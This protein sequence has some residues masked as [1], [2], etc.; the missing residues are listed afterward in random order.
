MKRTVLTDGTNRWF[1]ED[2]SEYFKEGKR[3]DGSNNISLST[4]S[5]WEH[6]AL[7]RT[8]SGIWVLNWWSGYQG[9]QETYLEITDQEASEWFIKNE[10]EIEELPKNIRVL[11][12]KQ[13]EELEI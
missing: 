12:E 1:N 9:V 2:S 11:V 8:K 6:E 5:Q 7:Y 3:W 10:Y 13:V 4:G